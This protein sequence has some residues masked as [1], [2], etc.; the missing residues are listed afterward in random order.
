MD[1][2]SQNLS[3]GLRIYVGLFLPVERDGHQSEDTSRYGD[4]GDE[5]VNRAIETSE[6]PMT[7][8][9]EEDYALEL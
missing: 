2:C 4:V 1:L 9:M 7:E 3:W 6:W 5:I 8:Q